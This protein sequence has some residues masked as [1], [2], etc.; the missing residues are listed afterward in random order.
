MSIKGF[1]RMT[2][3]SPASSAGEAMVNVQAIA[4]LRRLA[5]GPRSTV[6]GTEVLLVD[7]TLFQVAESLLDLTRG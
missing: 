1:I 4:R 7:G 5:T 3:T 2:I 6:R